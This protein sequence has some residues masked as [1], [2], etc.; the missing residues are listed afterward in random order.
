MKEKRLLVALGALSAAL[1]AC[2]SEVGPGN[3]DPDMMTGGTGGSSAAPGTGG[4]SASTGK[5]GTTGKGTGGSAG[6]TAPGTGGTAMTTGGTGGTAG[7][8]GSGGTG[9]V[10][11]CTPGVPASSQIP[12]MK[13]QEYDAVVK[14][15]V[16]LTALTSSGNM[17]PSSLLADDFE[18]EMTDIAWNGYLNAADKIAAEVMAGPNKSQFIACDPAMAGCLE[19]TIETFGR[20]AF[21]RPLSAEEK[22]SFLRLNNLTPKGTP[23]EVAEAILFAFLA[24]PSFI[25]LPE[26]EEAQ[27]EAGAIKLTPYEVATRLSFL[28][29]GTTPDAELSLAADNGELA[30]KE[31]ILAQAQRMVQDQARTGPAVAAFHRTY[32]DI[33]VGTHWN[34]IPHDPAKFPAYTDAAKAPMMAEIDRFFEDV[35]FKNGS[36]KDL[37]LSN[38]AYVNQDTAALYGLDKTAY[39]PELTRVELDAQQRPGFL[40]RVGFLSSFSSYGASSPV[41]RGAYITKNILGVHIDDPPP[42]AADTPVPPGDYKTQRQ[43]IEA[44]TGSPTCAGCHAEL[45]NPAGFVLERYNSVGM[46]QDVDALGGPIDGTADVLF[47]QDVIKTIT[48]PLE[49]MTE[50]GLGADAK[51]RYA[52]KWVSFATGRQPNPNDACVVNDLS[53][54]LSADG[55]TIINLLTDLTQADSFRLR[56]IGQ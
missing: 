25:M 16:G 39:G 47:N 54:K 41:L 48:S 33:R 37:F 18:G 14:D 5:G 29:W 27:M 15:L 8:P 7:D 55:Y 32:A 4:S 40:T 17:P 38:V 19:S 35:A 36:F 49:L 20:K 24:S 34:S 3:F 2:G 50:L 31:Q 26:L 30:T 51:R 6:S 28:L 21:R 9:A 53:G 11:S 42:E 13:N 56:T 10:T 44:L 52:E 12:R 43:V 46:Y 1:A 22:T 45:I 23:A